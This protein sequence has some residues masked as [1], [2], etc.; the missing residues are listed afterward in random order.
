MTY[1]MQLCV[2][3]DGHWAPKLATVE[4]EKLKKSGAITVSVLLTGTS[5]FKFHN[6]IKCIIV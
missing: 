4:E 5:L 2:F 1:D 3:C 6:C